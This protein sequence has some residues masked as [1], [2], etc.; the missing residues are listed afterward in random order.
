MNIRSRYACRL[1]GLMLIAATPVAHADVLSLAAGGSGEFL[2]RNLQTQGMSQSTIT[3]PNGANAGTVAGRDAQDR[4]YFITGSSGAQ[5]LQDLP[6]AL[7]TSPAGVGLS[8]GYRVT[9][10]AYDAQR[11]RIV[12]LAFDIPLTSAF[13][14]AINPASA[15]TTVLKPVDPAW[16]SYRAGV[17]AYLASPNQ[18][19]LVGKTSALSEDRLLRFDLG[20]AAS[21]LTPVDFDVAGEVVLALAA[22]PASGALYGLSKS[23]SSSIT[24]LVR[25]DFTPGFAVV[26]LGVGDVDCCSVLVGSPAIDVATNSLYAVTRKSNDPARLRRFNLS[27][28]VITELGTTVS[29][30]LFADPTPPLFDR[31]FANGF[32]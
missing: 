12:S 26:A 18:L 30:G 29:A 4:V 22:H 25:F 9:H 17:I 13:I 31:I 7:A 8:A 16:I 6:Y 1:A 11:T 3:T 15:A 10:A 5:T 14:N 19:Y 27:T 21:P 28:G 20:S 2:V 32:D 24:R 23:L